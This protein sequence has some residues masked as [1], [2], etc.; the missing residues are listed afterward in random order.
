MI[1]GEVLCGQTKLVVPQPLNCIAGHDSDKVESVG[2][3]RCQQ[4]PTFQ[5]D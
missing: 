2:L 1:I 4:S 5:G 3:A